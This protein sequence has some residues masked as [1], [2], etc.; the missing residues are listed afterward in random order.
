MKI[1]N[2]CTWNNLADIYKKVTDRNARTKHM[3]IIWNWAERRK[4]L[5]M[6]NEDE[7]LTFI[8]K[9]ELLE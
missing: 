1:N 7:T 5:F 8:G 9:K 2:P 6:L 4:D 3:D